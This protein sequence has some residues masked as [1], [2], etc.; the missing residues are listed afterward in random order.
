MMT[1]VNAAIERGIDEVGID[2]AIISNNE[3]G[4]YFQATNK[5]YN[6]SVKLKKG[7]NSISIDLKNIQINNAEATIVIA[8]WK[9]NKG[10][11]LFWWRIPVT[12][13]G[14]EFSTGRNHLEVSYEFNKRK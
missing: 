1:V 12:F 11:Y 10:E 14:V 8:I 2:S 5:A 7:R 13:K 4:L 9:K 3:A 6:K